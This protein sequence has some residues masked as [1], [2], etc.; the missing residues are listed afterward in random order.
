[1]EFPSLFMMRYIDEIKFA[2]ALFT[3]H[4]QVVREHRQ[5][6]IIFPIEISLRASKIFIYRQSYP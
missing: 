5:F 1:M 3:M 6:L 4:W 2:L